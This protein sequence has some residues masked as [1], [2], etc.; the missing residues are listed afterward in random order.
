MV[1]TYQLQHARIGRPRLVVKLEQVVADRDP[2]AQLQNKLGAGEGYSFSGCGRPPPPPQPP[3]PASACADAHPYRGH[4]AGQ[5]TQGL[6]VPTERVLVLPAPDLDR[7][8]TQERRH[9]VLVFAQHRR[10]LIL[11][12]VQLALGQAECALPQ[13][14]AARVCVQCLGRIQLCRRLREERAPPRRILAQRRHSQ[15]YNIVHAHRDIEKRGDARESDTPH[16]RAPWP[17]A[18]CTAPRGR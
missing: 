17:P 4:V 8:H 15:Y 12:V 5:D 11:G 9:I 7:G 16:V 18:V 3:T 1:S 2:Q 10:K 6:L 13:Q 14:R